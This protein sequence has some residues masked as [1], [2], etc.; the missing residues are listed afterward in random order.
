MRL[1]PSSQR[2]SSDGWDCPCSCFTH[3]DHYW[4]G[5]LEG[6]FPKILAQGSPQTGS[7]LVATALIAASN[8]PLTVVVSFAWLTESTSLATLAIWVPT[9]G[10]STCVAMT[11]SSIFR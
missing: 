3:R 1:A 10:L 11:A 7:P 8:M 9:V 2:S 4:R 6:D 5:H